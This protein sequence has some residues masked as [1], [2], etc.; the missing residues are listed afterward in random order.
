MG[1][2][3]RYVA[4][5]TDMGHGSQ[6]AGHGS[7]FRWVT[8][9]WVTLLDPLPALV[10]TFVN[11]Y[12][13][14]QSSKSH[15]YSDNGLSQHSIN[16]NN[17]GQK[18]TDCTVLEAQRLGSKHVSSRRSFYR[19]MLCIAQTM[20]SQDVCLSVCYTPVFCRNG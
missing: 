18:I 3:S 6:A 10:S 12:H 4:I 14:V 17:L 1:H 19:G 2:G 7:Q 16:V 9:S 11:S 5:V 13:A 8:G 15:I 20:L